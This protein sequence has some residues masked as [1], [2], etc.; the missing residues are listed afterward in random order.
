MNFICLL[1][2]ILNNINYNLIWNKFNNNYLLHLKY[3]EF[4]KDLILKITH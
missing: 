1:L 4:I 3:F 2:R